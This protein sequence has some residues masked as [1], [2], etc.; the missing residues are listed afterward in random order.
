MNFNQKGQNLLPHVLKY[1]KLLHVGNFC[2]NPFRIKT[3]GLMIELIG[4]IAI[5]VH[6]IISIGYF[7]RNHEAI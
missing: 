3:I 1:F 5:V 6:M 4:V 7:S 2:L